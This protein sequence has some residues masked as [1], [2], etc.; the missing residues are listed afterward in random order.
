MR[1]LIALIDVSDL[2]DERVIRIRVRQQRAD[3]EEDLGDGESGR[4]LVFQD[5]KADGAIAVDVHMVNFRGEGDL[6]RLER[7][8]GREVDVQEEDTLV[9]GRVLRAHD[10]R[11]PVELVSLVGGTS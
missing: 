10:R 5:V 3:R 9:I 7:I 4:P 2:G 8:V 1:V 11:L 6:G